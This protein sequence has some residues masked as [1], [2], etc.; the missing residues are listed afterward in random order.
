MLCGAARVTCFQFGSV[1]FGL[2]KSIVSCLMT[3]VRCCVMAVW[4]DTVANWS[5]ECE[6]SVYLADL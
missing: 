4:K 2:D 6:Q 5:S 3:T 1:F